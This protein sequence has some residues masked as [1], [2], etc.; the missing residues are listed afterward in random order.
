MIT[1]PKSDLSSQETWCIQGTT[2]KVINYSRT[3]RT[4]D[5][6]SILT[7]TAIMKGTLQENGERNG[8]G[9]KSDQKWTYSLPIND[10]K[11]E[12]FPVQEHPSVAATCQYPARERRRPDYYGQ[13]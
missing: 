12:V 11:R 4:K 13:N 3:D 2:P 9:N 1:M 8:A 7:T 6:T 10:M 5:G